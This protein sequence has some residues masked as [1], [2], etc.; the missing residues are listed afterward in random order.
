MYACMPYSYHIFKQHDTLQLAGL[1][2]NTTQATSFYPLHVNATHAVAIA[3]NNQNNQRL[4]YFIPHMH[5]SVYTYRK[6][7]FYSYVFNIMYMTQ[8]EYYRT[9]YLRI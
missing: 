5:A 1:Q 6:F 4:E 7:L 8:K 3:T 9:Y 2:N